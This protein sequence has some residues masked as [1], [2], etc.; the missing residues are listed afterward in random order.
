M[1]ISIYKNPFVFEKR[2]PSFSKYIGLCIYY[3]KNVKSENTHRHHIIPKCFI[4]E[5]IEE[6]WN[7][8]HL[9]HDVHR[10]AH[11]LIS[12]A[13]PEHAGLQRAAILMNNLSLSGFEPWNK[14]KTGLYTHSES[15]IQKMKESRKGEGNAM[16]NRKHTDEAIAKQK[17]A[18]QNR[19]GPNPFANRKHTDES[20]NKNRLAHLGKTATAETKIIMGI[21]QR[22]SEYCKNRPR[23]PCPYCDKEITAANFNKHVESCV[24]NPSSKKHRNKYG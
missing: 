4:G 24:E 10:E 8:V 18:A 6:R 13:I 7:W 19:E 22:N 12:K 23:T 2:G 1:T 17:N 20:N 21:S 16:W 9:E 15:T 3:Y 11:L 5:Y 14:G